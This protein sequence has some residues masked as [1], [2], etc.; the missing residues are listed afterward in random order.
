MSKHEDYPGLSD[1]AIV[2]RA[3]AELGRLCREIWNGNKRA[4]HWEIPANPKRDS[5]LIIG[6]GLDI[7][8]KLLKEKTPA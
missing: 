1:E 8:A 7:A 5:D 4:W 6:A 3:Q 2:K